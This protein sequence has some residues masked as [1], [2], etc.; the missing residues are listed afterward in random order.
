MFTL[1]SLSKYS[2]FDAIHLSGHFLHC[3][4]QLLNSSILM[5]FSA[6][7]VFC[8]NS[9]TLAKHFLLRTLFHLGKLKKKYVEVRSGEQGGWGAKTAEHSALSGQVCS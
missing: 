1:Q 3:S 4:E 8:I 5:P 9:S 7:A 6:S 2:P